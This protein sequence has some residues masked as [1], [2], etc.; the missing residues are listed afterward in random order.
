[1]K[2]LE[3]KLHWARVALHV[4]CVK[5]NVDFNNCIADIYGKVEYSVAAEDLKMIIY[6]SRETLHFSD[7]DMLTHKTKIALHLFSDATRFCWVVFIPGLILVAA[8]LQFFLSIP[9]HFGSISSQIN[10]DPS[11]FSEVEA[12]RLLGLILEL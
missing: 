9:D 3:P 6:K 4:V 11:V 5:I 7:L 8:N 12:S 10:L 2:I 1:M